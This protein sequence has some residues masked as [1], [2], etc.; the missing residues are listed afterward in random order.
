LIV[1][2]QQDVGHRIVVRRIVGVRYGRTL[3][4][5][6]LGELVELT[7][8]HL[9]IATA[10]GVVQVPLTEVHRAKRVPPARRPMAS[11][12]VDLERAANEAWPAPVQDRMGG[13][14]LRAAGGWTGRANSALPIGDPDRP[15]DAAID[16]VVAW[17]AG[18]GQPA[19]INVPLPLAAPVGVA[20]DERG[21][22]ARPLTLV[23]TA[24]LT[25]VL[26]AAPA[27]SPV[28]GV[29]E[30][31]AEP[32]PGW[33]ALAGAG[34]AARSGGREDGTLPAA[35]RHVLTAVGTVRFAHL[36]AESGDQSGEGDLLAIARGTVT[37]AGRWLGISLIEVVP[38][39]RRRGLAAWL[40]R[41]LAEWAAELGATDAFLQV[42]ERNAE[43]VALY[44][45]L[46]F[47][48]HH[49]YLTR[50]APGHR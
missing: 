12:V 42:E 44:R 38:A 23:Q 5:D 48:T 33:L 47:R 50:V 34:K 27:G 10:R 29:P 6:A 3:F 43:A 32:S 40:I 14:L 37:G 4:S 1:L 18:H 16:A 13:W 35:A 7:E 2:R 26:T 49:T 25:T 21:W 8:T 19:M 39:A 45:K 28:F 15:L 41:A 31:A 11:A 36:Y 20:L 46:G 22:G 30:L 24:P 9:T 17:Y